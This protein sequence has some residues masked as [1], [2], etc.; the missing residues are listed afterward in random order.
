M[1]L[2]VNLP[3]LTAYCTANVNKHQRR[4]TAKTL[5]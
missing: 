4:S 3:A 2:Y 1:Q 5:V